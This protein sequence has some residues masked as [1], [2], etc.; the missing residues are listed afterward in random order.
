MISAII[1]CYNSEKTI[2]KCISSILSLGTMI[3]EIIIIDD[4]STDNT[5]SIIK[6]FSNSKI[7]LYVN[8][9]NHGPAYSRNK[10]VNISNSF[11]V[12]FCDSDVEIISANIEY[13]LIK[14]MDDCNFSG[15]QGVYIADCPIQ[16]SVSQYKH[17]QQIYH[18]SRWP[19]GPLPYMSTSLLILKRDYFLKYG[20][21]DQK[22][23]GASL[24][25]R[26]LGATLY[27]NKTPVWV[28]KDFKGYHYHHFTLLKLL[29]LDF[30]RARDE[31]KYS[32]ELTTGKTLVSPLKKF[33][34]VNFLLGICL[35]PFVYFSLNVLYISVPMMI[36]SV[37]YDVYSIGNLKN[38]V[39]WT[40]PLISFLDLFAVSTGAVYGL[41]L[42]IL[43]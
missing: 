5:I 42:K 27:L 33:F 8:E 28:V 39:L 16:S 12:L 26:I 38:D 35:F 17:W 15:L 2:E 22:I 25:D 7:K 14:G 3:S 29:K 21:L 4:C 18:Q 23:K 30:K 6:K 37:F 34:Y 1:P 41:L 31:L 36:S 19:S 32:D 11:Y 10:A 40:W 43:I 9:V 20:G 24:E 13:K